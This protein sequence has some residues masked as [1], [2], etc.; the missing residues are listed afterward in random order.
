MQK[1]ISVTIAP[2]LRG[3]PREETGV[4]RDTVSMMVRIREMDPMQK[5]TNKRTL[6]LIACRPTTNTVT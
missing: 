6:V 3:L 4:D 5:R 2:N 1:I